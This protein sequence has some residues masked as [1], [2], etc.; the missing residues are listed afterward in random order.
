VALGYLIV[1]SV[2]FA[3]SRQGYPASLILIEEAVAED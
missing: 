1:A 2:C 3:L